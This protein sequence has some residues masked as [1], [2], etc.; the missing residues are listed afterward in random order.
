M[1][2]LLFNK[3]RPFCLLQCIWYDVH[4]VIG[5]EYGLYREGLSQG[6]CLARKKRVRPFRRR[7]LHKQRRWFN[8]ILCDANGLRGV[9]LELDIAVEDLGKKPGHL[10]RSYGD[11]H[12][13]ISG[14][15]VSVRF[16]V[17]HVHRDAVLA[18][19]AALYYADLT[20]NHNE[21]LMGRAKNMRALVLTRARG[22]GDTCRTS[23][24][25]VVKYFILAFDVISIKH[26]R[27]FNPSRHRVFQ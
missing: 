10:L 25:K 22:R 15:K 11:A 27:D 16:A 26:E 12:I 21:L 2:V 14:P 7:G 17:Q 5:S 19:V 20:I 4:I 23:S 1:D 8:C 24:L 13:A 9:Q 3:N 18:V 6:K